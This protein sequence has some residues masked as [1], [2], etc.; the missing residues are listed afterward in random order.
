[1]C[2]LQAS[3]RGLLSRQKGITDVYFDHFHQLSWISSLRQPHIAQSTGYFLLGFGV[4]L[5]LFRNSLHFSRRKWAELGSVH[6][7]VTAG[8]VTC[9]RWEASLV[10]WL[11]EE[12]I[13]ACVWLEK[14]E[15][16]WEL[17]TST[18]IGHKL[19]LLCSQWVFTVTQEK[20]W[21]LLGCVE[22]LS[23]LLNLYQDILSN[24][25]VLNLVMLICTNKQWG[26]SR[27]HES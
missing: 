3:R 7:G 19:L 12:W 5:L 22:H 18:F 25:R 21:S 10:P 4:L 16:Q 14:G 11:K 23:R 24:N 17:Y 20:D 8:S 1:M 15:G 26:H 2:S 9:E 13:L 6:H 27:S